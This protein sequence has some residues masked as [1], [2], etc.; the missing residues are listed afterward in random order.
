MC[1][2]CVQNRCG[3]VLLN[4]KRLSRRSPEMLRELWD[5]SPRALTP[6]ASDYTSCL[7]IKIRWVKQFVFFKG[8]KNAFHFYSPIKFSSATRKVALVH[9]LL[10]PTPL[11][12]FLTRLKASGAGFFSRLRPDVCVNL[13]KTV[14]KWATAPPLVSQEETGAAQVRTG[15]GRLCSG[16]LFRGTAIKGP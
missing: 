3:Q 9:P 4:R 15:Q 13:N 10:H 8:Y 11:F 7:A 2:R 16:P 1:N 12:G 14:S 6:R 5:A